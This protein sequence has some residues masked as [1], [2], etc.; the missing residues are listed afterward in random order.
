MNRKGRFGRRLTL[1]LAAVLMVTGFAF[2]VSAQEKAE[3]EAPQILVIPPES[4]SAE[5]SG[6][7][8]VN[9]NDDWRFQRETGGSITGAQAPDFDDHAWR[10]LTLPHDWS[11]ELDFNASSPATHEGGF[12]DGGTGWYRKTFTLPA[13]MAGKR[14]SIDFDG[15]YMN[16]TT[17]L[18]GQ[19]LGTYPYGYNSFSYDISDKVYTD[20]RENV[21]A[22][23]VNNTQPSSRWYSGSGIYRNVYLTVTNPVHVARYGTFVTTPELEKA[24][25]NGKA[26]VQIVTK[27]ANDSAAAAEVSVKS[28]IVDANGSTVAAIESKKVMAGAGKVTSFED[29][30]SIN[31][32]TLWSTTN[33]Y[34]YKVVTEVIKDGQTVDTYE[35]TFGA[36]YFKLDKNEGFSLNGQYM[37]LHGVSMHHDLGALGAATNARALERQMQ[38]MK[39]MGVNAIRT[40]H[41]PASPELLEAC[42]KL[43]LL[44]IE[45]AFDAW[46]Q[47]KKSYDYARFFSAW[48]DRFAS[49]WAE[50]DIKEMVDRDKNEPSIIMWSLG[51]EIYDT[52][53]ANGAAT[54]GKLVDW[55]KQVDTTRPTTI[56]QNSANSRPLNSNIK[57]VLD[58]VDVVGLN[59]AENNYSYFHE[60]YPNW[61]MYGSETSS[62]T[63][64]RGVYTH[65]NSN[66]KMGTYSDLQQSSY[67][68]DSVSWGRTAEDAWKQER[69]LKYIAGQ[70]I[71]TG[72]DYIGEPTPYYDTFPSKSSYFGAVDTAGFPKDIFYYYQSQWTKEP[73]VHLLP[74]W[75]WKEGE[76]VRVLAYTNAKKVELI[77]NGTSLGEQSFESKTTS[78]GA[79]YLETST[80]KTYLEWSVPFKTGTLE[81]VAKDE[82]GKEVARDRVVTAGAPAA[83]R[84]MADRQVISA[85]GTDL[86]FVTADIVDSEGRIVPTADNQLQ[87]SVSG[88]GTIA[89]VDNGNAASVERYKDN[90]RKAF[91]GKA[92]AI[93]QSTQRAG[94]IKLTVSSA[95]LRGDSV[96]VF[97]V[98]AVDGGEKTVAGVESVQVLTGIGEAPVLPQS[99][100]VHY[101][102]GSSAMKTVVWNSVEPG[103]YAKINQ[104]EV[105]GTV[106]GISLKASAIITVKG[107]MAVKTVAVTT[108]VGSM[109]TLPSQVSLIFSD[110][111]MVSVNVAWDPISP[112]QIAQEGSFTVEGRVAE[113]SLKAK[114]EIRV[115]NE[116][117]RVNIMLRQNGSLFP[118]LEATYTGTGDNL[119]HIND[120]IKSYN[121]N[122]K[123]RWTNWTG[124]PRDQGDSITVNFGRTYTIDNLDLFVFTD[125]GTAV[126][127]KVTVQYWNGTAWADVQN[128]KEPSPY[129]VQKNEI[130]F[131]PVTTDKLKFHM[132]ASEA[133]KFSALTEVEVYA[134]QIAMSSTAELAGITVGGSALAGFD[135]VKRDYELTLPYGSQLPVIE[136]AGKDHAAVTVVPAIAL[137]GTAK[138]YVTSEDGLASTEYVIHL[139]T[140]EAKLVSADIEA[141]KTELT[142]DEIID[143]KVTG[144]LENGQKTD[145]TGTKPVY[146]YDANLIRIESNKLYALQAGQAKVAAEVTYNGTK[147]TTRE[148]TFTISP[149]VS[150]KVIE[151]L[152][153][154]SVITDPGVAPVLPKTVVAHYKTGL[155]KPVAVTWE[156]VAPEK[157]GSLGTFEVSGSVAGTNLKAKAV[158]TVKGAIAVENVALAVLRKQIPNLPT[159]VTVYYSDGTDERK[160]VAWE[161]VP[162]GSLDQEGTFELAGTVEGTM[163][164]SKALVRVTESVGDEQNIAMA[165]NGYDHP[166][167]EASFTNLGPASL[168]RL[169]AINDGIISYEETP[170]NRWTNWQRTPRSSDWVSITFGD[171]KPVEYDVDNM[172]IHWFGDQGTS[173]PASFKIQYKSGDSWVDVKNLKSDPASPALRQANKLSFDMVKTSALRVDMTAQT[174][175]GIGIT[176]IKVFSR[177]PAAYTEP[178]VTDILLGGKSVIDGFTPKSG[179]G[180]EYTAEIADLSELRSITAKGTNNTAITVIPAVSAPADA[181]ILAKSEDGNKS[182]SYTIHFKLKDDGTPKRISALLTGP[183]SVK[184]EED[185]L[186]DMGLNHVDG[187]VQAQDITLHYDKDKFEFIRAELKEEHIQ[188]VETA[189]GTPGQVRVI[190]VS[191]GADHAI[192]E[193]G[194]FLKLTFKSKGLEQTVSGRIETARVALGDPEGHETEAAPASIQV[195]VSKEVNPPGS[196]DLNGDGR[197]SIGDLAIAAAHY[198]KTSESPDWN[199]AKRAD[200]NGD[201]KIDISDLAAIA[202]KIVG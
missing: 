134:D 70:F 201:G 23:K 7:R 197:I 78:W 128:V 108:K 103:L 120:G 37:K 71:W 149:N 121:D 164:K 175:M 45:E 111:S 179:G 28:T 154:A 139:K 105:Q 187:P 127:S 25:A 73:M 63:R 38:I 34:L 166:K 92:L 152:E 39:D 163:L 158:V 68:N 9:F 88:S 57:N 11:I 129:I 172:E 118:Q 173:Y 115:T 125:F 177:R 12:L 17:Y 145:L 46:N 60:Q 49:T 91:S 65:P 64:S 98:P 29:K 161:A 194:S 66:N 54:A 85:D 16:S 6:E 41:N 50:H 26:D 148:I 191:T 35:T 13:S 183:A 89:G 36:R 22:V 99:V 178:K 81:A 33:P 165:K 18:N 181:T 75:N 151:S 67:D 132:K 190:A 59:Y 86:S 135:A 182:V 109:P 48:S 170:H 52:S 95:G 44:V 171:F 8:K 56:G 62:A 97:S 130:R 142:E 20:G 100:K 122:P 30:K 153:P 116:N 180:F 113:T 156:P 146:A 10:S 193:D 143:L 126:P 31:H 168:D 188:I 1:C 102:D 90:K 192:R 199:Q 82:Q 87:F 77:L 138:I 137:P 79:P 202:K 27:V 61:I 174:G 141:S 117:R 32:P 110:D 104:F 42:N 176:E 47:S 69:D 84:L 21:I 155:P 58:V 144:Q 160:N 53:S 133:G 15:V 157:Y 51:N 140:E 93:L 123:N 124:S 4:A 96:N 198:G 19:V 76:T 200:V 3:P 185:F 195:E 159:S 2:P 189:A 184:P 40:T 150:E 112:S 5:Y 24:Y 131:D 43:G 114:A 167:A 74:H 80:G 106:E 119:N 169:E 72:F 83:V 196:I 14:L 55:V 107:I 101:S 136:A 162:S 186:I 147:V 94:E